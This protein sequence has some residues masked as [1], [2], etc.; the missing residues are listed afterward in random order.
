MR[1]S[2]PGVLH[3]GA[4]ALYDDSVNKFLHGCSRGGRSDAEGI[5]RVHSEPMQSR[6]PLMLMPITRDREKN[7]G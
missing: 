5:E 7:P 4:G 2:S 3:D 1:A 6:G